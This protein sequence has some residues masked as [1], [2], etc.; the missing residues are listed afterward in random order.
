MG[1]I[2]SASGYVSVKTDSGQW[3]A[4]CSGG[5]GFSFTSANAAVVCRQL[6]L[7]WAGATYCSGFGCGEFVTSQNAGPGYIGT[8]PYVSAPACLG[9]E[10]Q[11]DDCPH[12]VPGFIAASNCYNGDA[13]M[14]IR[15]FQ[16]FFTALSHTDK[17][18]TCSRQMF[19]WALTS[20]SRATVPA[21]LSS[22]SAWHR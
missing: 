19:Q 11:I 22:F 21:Y 20:A 18:T 14:A 4:V 7:P 1:G 2:S 12:Y 13:G 3:A 6:G 9:H 8:L 15:L 16:H 5:P 17:C 10:S